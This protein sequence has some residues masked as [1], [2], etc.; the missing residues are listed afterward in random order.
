V[1]RG[2]DVAAVRCVG[3]V[4]ASGCDVAGG[5]CVLGEGAEDAFERLEADRVHVEQC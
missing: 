1:W 3:G 4:H 5:G 2:V